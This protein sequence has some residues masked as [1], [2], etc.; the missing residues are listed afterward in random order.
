MGDVGQ[1][2]KK[3]HRYSRSALFSF[4][5]WIWNELF[6]A[7]ICCGWPRCFV[8]LWGSSFAGL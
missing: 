2:K 8:R 6:P 1:S 5:L 7:F 4:R 3:D